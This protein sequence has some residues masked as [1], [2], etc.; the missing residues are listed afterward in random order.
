MNLDLEHRFDFIIFISLR[1]CHMSYS[2]FCTNFQCKIN[3]FT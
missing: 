2:Y 3:M 1:L